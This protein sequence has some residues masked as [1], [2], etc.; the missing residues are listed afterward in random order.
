MSCRDH[1]GAP[2]SRHLCVAPAKATLFSAGAR[3]K[4]AHNATRLRGLLFGP[5]RVIRALFETVWHEWRDDY[6]PSLSEVASPRHVLFP[7]AI[8]NRGGHDEVVY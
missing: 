2:L 3:L 8:I 7:W 5:Q 1:R 4:N 6:F